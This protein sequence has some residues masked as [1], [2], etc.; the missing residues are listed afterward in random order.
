MILITVDLYRIYEYRQ[1]PR[2]EFSGSWDESLQEVEE[3]LQSLTN[4][5]KSNDPV[6]KRQIKD[7]ET[8]LSLFK[9]VPTIDFGKVL[10]NKFETKSFEIKNTSLIPISW[11][12]DFGELNMTD[13]PNSGPIGSLEKKKSSM[14]I[15]RPGSAQ[16]MSRPPSS[17]LVNSENAATTSDGQDS[18]RANADNS[19]SNANTSR[20]DEGNKDNDKSKL[21]S[22]NPSS[23]VIA[24]LSSVLVNISFSNPNEYIL[25]KKFYVRYSDNEGGL[26]STPQPI[27]ATVGKNNTGLTDCSIS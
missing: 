24:P 6:V 23:G 13:P 1:T 16:V 14:N 10:L 19:G 17:K 26:L 21:V 3:S 5:S 27:A 4:S 9:E 20:M 8:K 22:I 2:V 15:S 25:S 12:I 18:N 11:E 7:L